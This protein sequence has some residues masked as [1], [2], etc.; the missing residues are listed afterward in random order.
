MLSPGKCDPLSSSLAVTP[1]KF[2][3]VPIKGIPV[4]NQSARP[5]LNQQCQAAAGATPLLAPH[6]AVSWLQLWSSPTFGAC[7]ST[8][9]FFA[10]TLLQVHKKTCNT[11]VRMQLASGNAA[12][13]AKSI[14]LNPMS[15]NNH[16][17]FLKGPSFLWGRFKH[18]PSYFYD[19]GRY[20]L[21]PS[22]GPKEVVSGNI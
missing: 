4:F 8:S 5:L 10:A 3:I 19:S 21:G 12:M 17:V 14:P 2:L 7:G 11:A 15:R 9:A 18:I 16:L 22:I 1:G 6:P 20:N 13:W